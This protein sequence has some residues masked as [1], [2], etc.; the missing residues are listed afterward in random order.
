MTERIDAIVHRFSDQL[1]YSATLSDEPAWMTFYRRLWPNMIAAVRIDRN[2]QWQKDGIDREIYLPNGKRFTIDEKKRKKDYGDVLLEEW[3]VFHGDA[4]PRN[5]VGWA[6]DD[7]KRCDF[8]AY[9][10]PVS[11][12]CYFLPFEI[13]RQSFIENRATW[14]RAFPAR[15]AWNEGYV[16]RSIAV[17]WPTLKVALLQQMF[18]KFDAVALQLPCAVKNGRQME[19][20]WSPESL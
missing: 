4:D 10:V 15:D 5:K 8:V 1:E 7:S 13:L 9:A 14:S 3:S 6:L 19:F 2:S 17:T 18:R 20:P 16:T 11:C 12:K